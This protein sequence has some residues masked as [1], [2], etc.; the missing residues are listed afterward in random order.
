MTLALAERAA[1]EVV[2]I[3]HGPISDRVQVY[4]NIAR[5]CAAYAVFYGAMAGQ[6]LIALRQKVGNRK[7]QPTLAESM[8]WLSH[9]TAYLYIGYAEKFESRLKAIC[10]TAGQIKLA[11]LPD[12]RDYEAAERTELFEQVREKTGA[13]TAVQMWLALGLMREPKPRGGSKAGRKKAEDPSS[14][15]QVAVDLWK[16]HLDFLEND[17]LDK[18]SWRDLPK[19]EL[20]RLS[21]LLIDLRKA[22]KK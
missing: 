10:P 11:A 20:T 8:P 12:P 7:F 14:P 9:S 6:E 15:A 2:V 18:C 4:H 5:S 17:G 16:P 13:E 3:E 22:M 21:G 1:G 19:A